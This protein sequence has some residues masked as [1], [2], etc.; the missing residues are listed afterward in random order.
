MKAFCALQTGSRDETMHLIYREKGK[1]KNQTTKQALQQWYENI[2]TA[3]DPAGDYNLGAELF[4]PSSDPQR[5]SASAAEV[6]LSSSLLVGSWSLCC[7]PKWCM[8]STRRMSW[9]KGL[10]KGCYKGSV[11]FLDSKNASGVCN[12][13]LG[14][15]RANTCVCWTHSMQDRQLGF[16]QILFFPEH[17][18]SCCFTSWRMPYLHI[19]VWFN[20]WCMH[21]TLWFLEIFFFTCLLLYCLWKSQYLTLSSKTISNTS[22]TFLTQHYNLLFQSQSASENVGN[23]R[24]LDV[25]ATAE[26]FPPPRSQFGRKSIP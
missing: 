1:K 12:P 3:L 25:R 23:A 24:I 15:Y 6:F 8:Q 9:V 17:I 7:L 16:Q 22:W 26:R 19:E 5:L 13:A 20:F 11:N 21:S 14:T 2:W 4:F 18:V 10:D